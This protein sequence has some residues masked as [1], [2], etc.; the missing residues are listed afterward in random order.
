MSISRKLKADMDRC[1]KKIAEGLVVFDGIWKK[2]YS[3]S[4]HSQ[5]EKL[6]LELKKELKKL[7][8]GCCITPCRVEDSNLTQKYMYV[9]MQRCRDNIKSWIANNVIKDKSILVTQ[10]RLIEKRMEQFKECEKEVKTKAYSKEGLAKAEVIDSED[11]EKRD[12][13]DWVQVV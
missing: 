2:V 5:R 11:E 7:Q 3:T 8:V 9:Y 10:R 13:V 1:F 12:T 6:S 4:E